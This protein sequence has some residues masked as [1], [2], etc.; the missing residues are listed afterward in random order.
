MLVRRE[1][2]RV[3]T[4]PL[5]GP[6]RRSGDPMIDAENIKQ[7][8]VSAKEESELTMCTDVDRNDKS[9]V[10]VPGTVQLIGRR[11]IES[12]AGLFHTVDHVEGILKP[13][14][15]AIDAFLSHMWAVTLIGA[16]KKAA[17]QAVENLEKDARGWYGGAV[18]LP[19][20]DGD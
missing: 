14:F 19:S 3:E 18:R 6:V 5:A 4:C 13:G 8:L 17:A 11:L 9:R 16:P 7:L 15:D 20:L 12:Y 10:C 1:G 2:P